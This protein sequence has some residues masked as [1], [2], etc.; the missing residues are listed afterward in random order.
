M[1]SFISLNQPTPRRLPGLRASL[2]PPSWSSSPRLCTARRSVS[3]RCIPSHQSALECRWDPHLHAEMQITLSIAL[4]QYEMQN[5]LK[6]NLN[7]HHCE[8]SQHVCLHLFSFI[9][10]LFCLSFM[11]AP[12]FSPY[13]FLYF[14]FNRLFLVV[15][16]SLCT[17][18]YRIRASFVIT[19][20]SSVI[21]QT[22]IFIWIIFAEL[23]LKE[24]GITSF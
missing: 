18:I 3:P 21:F 12:L 9:I 15:L 24:F 2:A 1:C 7:N 14:I 5:W 23:F 8:L 4:N 17:L 11:H 20:L 16:F 13:F 10:V 19:F 6:Q 22:L